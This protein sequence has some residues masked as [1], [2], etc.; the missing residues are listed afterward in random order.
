MYLIIYTRSQCQNKLIAK[1]IFPYDLKPVNATPKL[2]PFL[3]YY[4]TPL[5][6]KSILNVNISPDI[7]IGP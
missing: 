1:Y 2:T 4:N 5:S 3:K 6:V 7:N